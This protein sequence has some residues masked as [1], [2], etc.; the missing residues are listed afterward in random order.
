MDRKCRITASCTVCLS[1]CVF[2]GRFFVSR[3]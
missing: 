1:Q 3:I 2:S